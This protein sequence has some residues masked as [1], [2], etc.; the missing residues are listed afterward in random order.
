MADS[1]KIS[2]TLEFLTQIHTSWNNTEQR[3]ALRKYPRRYVSYEYIGVN[4]WQ[5][6]YLRALLYSRQTEQ[7]EIPLWHAASALPEKTYIGQT[8]IPLKPGNIWPYRGCRG[9]ILWCNDEAGGD[10]YALQQ[11]LGDGTLKLGEQID[12]IYP[13]KRTMVCPVAYAILQQEDKY[14]LYNSINTSMQLNLELMTNEIMMPIP[15]SLDEYHD[16]PWQTKNPWQAAL[17][18]FH[19]G[20]EIFPIAPAW[21]NDISAKFSRNAN[22]LDN[23]SGVVKYDLKSIDT[24]ETKEIEYIATSRSEIYNLQ[25]FFCRCK[26]RLKSFY[27]PTWLSDMSLVAD[28][29]AGQNFL[30]VEWSLFWKYYSSLSRRKTI[31]VFLKDVTTLILPIAGFTTDDTGEHGKVILDSHLRVPLRQKDVAMISFLCRYR[32]DSDTMITNYETVEIASTAFRF[33]EVNA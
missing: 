10:H 23:Q 5:S 25:R 27:A 6:Q 3:M 18:A 22:R 14:D 12:T 9:V 16:E 19:M 7:I 26:G 17:P 1:T 13:P 24:S 33:T 31:V 4:S 30:L 8:E 28:A 32:H 20:V 2:E 15:A 11:L 21:A 29:E